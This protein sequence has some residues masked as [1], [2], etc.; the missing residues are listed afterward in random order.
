MSLKFVLTYFLFE[1]D[2]E[3]ATPVLEAQ[4]GSSG[5]RIS[6]HTL[7]FPDHWCLYDSHNRPEG[8]GCCST[9]K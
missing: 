9:S 4:L 8:L 1:K 3:T 5:Y 7:L 2:L 6:T